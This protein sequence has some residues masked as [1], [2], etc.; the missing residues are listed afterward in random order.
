M[1]DKANGA[2]PK[3]SNYVQ[4]IKDQGVALMHVLALHPT[5]LIAPALIRELVGASKDF[6]QSDR[7]ERAVR[8]LAGVG[9]LHCPG[10]LVQP[11][12][13]ALRF[14]EILEA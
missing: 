5:H 7:F 13:A 6:A 3:R 1:Q 8:D 11:T 9:L 2:R 14:I 12:R 4:D 10:G